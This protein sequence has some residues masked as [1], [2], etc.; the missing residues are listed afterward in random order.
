MTVNR[1]K[2]PRKSV[3]RLN[4]I[5]RDPDGAIIASCLV[6]DV[7]ERGVRLGV[8]AAEVL[9]DQFILQLTRN[10]RVLRRCRVVW[11]RGEEVGVEYIFGEQAIPQAHRGKGQKLKL[12]PKTSTE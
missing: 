5:A 8:K 10:G 11:R 2:K 1:R 4:V 9:P 6:R 7:S 12:T 3:N